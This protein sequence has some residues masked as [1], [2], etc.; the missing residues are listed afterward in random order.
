[1]SR[2]DGRVPSSDGV[3]I[4]YRVDEPLANALGGATETVVLV[5]GI[6]D[7]LEA[8]LLQV[9]DLLAAG[10]R[11]VSFDNRGLGLSGRP[12]GPYTSRQ[13]AAD[14]QAVV[15]ALGL[16]GFHLVGCSMGG[17]IAL[18]YALAEPARL[19]SLVLANTYAAPDAY[20][21]DILE[22]WAAILTA[23][24][25]PA[26]MRQMAPWIF[27]PAFHEA[28]AE[29]LAGFITEMVATPQTA[30]SFAAQL[31]ILHDHDCWARLGEIAVPALVLVAADDVFIR[32]DLSRRMLEGLPDGHWASVAGGHAVMWENPADWNGAIVAFV[33]D[34]AKA[35]ATS[36][37]IT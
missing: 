3:E 31:A 18:E 15:G 2:V 10:L 14:L 34:H 24:G 32:P 7:D 8:W 4:H 1:M 29:T 12:P 30:E 22:A 36:R 28:Q 19:R 27:S 20:T 35:A 6:G 25:M 23:G 17:L 26:V 11:V 37:R 9:P 16:D 21:R 33:R 13:G 5:N